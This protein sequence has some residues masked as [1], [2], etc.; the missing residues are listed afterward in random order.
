[1][2]KYLGS[3]SY[4]IRINDRIE[5]YTHISNAMS[6]GHT[7]DKTA[8]LGLL[9]KNYAL[10]TRT[11]VEGIERTPWMLRAR[12]TNDWEQIELPQHG[13]IMLNPEVIA[14]EM[15]QRLQ[16]EALTFLEGKARIGVL[17]SGGMDSRIVAAILKQLQESGEYSGDV[18]A[19]TWGLDDSRDVIYAQNIAERFNWEFLHFPLNADVLMDNIFIAADRG[20]EYSPIHLHAMHQISKTPGLDGVLAGSYGDSIGRGEYSGLHVSKLPDILDK[21]LNHFALMLRS[22]EKKALANIK[23]DIKQDLAFFPGRSEIAY[24]EIEM[25]M[26]YMRRQLNSC[27]EVIDDLIPLYQMFGSPDVY[28]YMWS[29]DPAC[30][31]DQNYEY[32]LKIL[33]G[34]LLD[35]PWA[36]TGTNFNQS[37]EEPIDSFSKSNNH[38]GKWLRKD[39][40]NFILDEIGSGALQSLGIFNNKSLAMW[41]RYWGNA[42]RLKADRLDEKM[43]WLASLSL[44]V[45]KYNIQGIDTPSNYSFSDCLSQTNAL[46]HTS[47]YHYALRV[48]KR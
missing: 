14:K 22:A 36:R 4:Y 44:F 37:S 2:Y 34:N 40:R 1:M 12:D 5:N 23:I 32:L 42:N 35:I 43:A 17:L 16:S 30:R 39:L 41:S 45:K 24:R 3:R 9:M 13:N 7:I 6:E 10:S 8:V 31:T 33:P 27:M 47:L 46:V 26:Y 48:L 15:K 19:L 20:A 38:Y 11:L 28:G 29:L 25:Q 21:N 18:V